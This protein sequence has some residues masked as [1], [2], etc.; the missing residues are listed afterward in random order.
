MKSLRKNSHVD[1]QAYEQ[2]SKRD[3]SLINIM[4]LFTPVSAIIAGFAV[5]YSINYLTEAWFI[6][7][8]FGALAG[9]AFYYH[10]TTLLGEFNKNVIYGRIFVSC[11]LIFSHIYSSFSKNSRELYAIVIIY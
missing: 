5:Y 7:M 9:T 3:K 11:F 10:D 8:I 4:A 2:S 1:E 6:A